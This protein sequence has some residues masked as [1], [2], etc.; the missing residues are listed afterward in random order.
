M[1]KTIDAARLR[2]LVSYDPQS[3]EFVARVDR[4]KVAAGQRLGFPRKDG[5]WR[6]T[7]DGRK[8]LCHRLAW[9]YVTGRWPKDQVDHADGNRSNN[10]FANLRECTNG[11]NRQNLSKQSFASRRSHVGV[12]YRHDRH[13]WTARLVVDGITHN[14]GHFSTEAAA[15]AAHEAKKAELHWFQPR[16]RDEEARLAA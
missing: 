12:W 1:G 6:M 8:Y 5:Y 2:D 13:A 7:I 16:F 3:G 14:L 15:I 11:E 10:A 9:L 4:H